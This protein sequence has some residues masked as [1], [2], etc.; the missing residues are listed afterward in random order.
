MQLLK[1]DATISQRHAA[2]L[3]NVPLSTLND[4]RAGKPSRRDT[5]NTQHRLTKHEEEV[6]VQQIRKL[7][8]R[9][10]AP[11][12]Q[13]VRDMANQLLAVRDGGMVGA[14]WVY[15]FIHRRD[16]VKSQVTR[17][18]DRQRVLCSDP[19]VISP[20]FNLVRN[21]KAKY[22]I[23]DKDTYN[24]DETGFQMGVG[25]SVKVV[26]ASERRIKPLGVQP[27]DREWV[28]LIA[29]INAMG[30]SIPPFF[31]LK[32]KHHNQA[33]YHQKDK[34]WRIA[35]SKNGWTTNEIG[36]AWL[37]HFLKHTNA[38]TVGGYRLLILDGHES[39]QSLLFQNRCEESKIITLCMPAHASHLLQPLDVG[40]FAALKRA[41]KKEI[42]ALANSHI[43]H[44][45]KKAFLDTYSK[46]H[47]DVF[48]SSNIKAGFRAAGLVPDNPGA[49]LLK[50]DVKPRTPTPPLPGTSWQP[51]TPSNALEIGAQSTLLSNRIRTHGS[52]SP[53]SMI[54]MVRQFQKGAEMM[55]H[56]QTLL[57]A[58]IAN[59][60]AAN[61]AA[62]ARKSHKKKRIQEGGTLSQ[63]EAEEII[64]QREVAEQVVEERRAER[65]L[66][67]VTRRSTPRCKGCGNAGHNMRTCGRD[68][69][70]SGG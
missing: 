65:R 28:T 32:A 68:A 18:R 37:E 29:G 56:S 45:D 33:W 13:Y 54:E 22:G 20:W 43:N 60:E 25:G 61:N 49:V 69:A 44:I 57:A 3:Y 40:C 67:G 15:R 24:F 59:L 66:A 34:D 62:S 46:V 27:G 9:G 51:K 10:F 11:T 12:L 26:T 64:N 30:W 58:R 4:R 36:L 16:D 55:V 5:Y 39:H 2:A 41:Y 63:A 38:R 17:L 42:G 8:E 50:L 53:A 6:I 23:L 70:E 21:V 52:S 7:D 19:E 48:S 1:S 31:I 14:N 35:V 47:D